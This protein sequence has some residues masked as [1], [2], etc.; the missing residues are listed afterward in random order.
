MDL[1]FSYSPSTSPTKQPGMGTPKQD[2]LGTDYLVVSVTRSPPGTTD[3]SPFKIITKVGLQLG[4]GEIANY[5]WCGSIHFH[6]NN[7]GNVITPLSETD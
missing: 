2:G 5:F 6:D 7:H 1:G 4:E 3:L